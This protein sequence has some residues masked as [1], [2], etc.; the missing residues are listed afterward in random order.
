MA[1]LVRPPREGR[2]RLLCHSHLCRG[3]GVWLAGIMLVCL[4]E[5][6]W[7]FLGVALIFLGVVLR[8]FGLVYWGFSMG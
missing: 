1:L 8:V 7:V 2:A 4:F 6:F 3:E 5:G